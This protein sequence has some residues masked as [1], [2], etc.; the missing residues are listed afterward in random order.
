MAVGMFAG[1]TKKLFAD[2][3]HAKINSEK[4]LQDSTFPFQ[5]SHICC[6]VFASPMSTSFPGSLLERRAGR[7]WEQGWANISGLCCFRTSKKISGEMCTCVKC[8]LKIKPF[9]SHLEN[10][11]HPLISADLASDGKLTSGIHMVFGMTSRRW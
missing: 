9:W 8:T 1:Y 4:L 7:P 3:L 11:G 2:Q 6:M 5:R 10:I